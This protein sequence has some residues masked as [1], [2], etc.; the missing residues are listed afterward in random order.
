MAGLIGAD[1]LV[2]TLLEKRIGID[3]KYTVIVGAVGLIFT[4]IQNP[5][6]ISGA[7]RLGGA[8]PSQ[9]APPR[10]RRPSP[11][12]RQTECWS[13]GALEHHGM[14]VTFGGL[15][16]VDDVDLEVEQG[17]LVGLIGPN[18]AGKTTLIGAD[19]LRPSTG[20]LV[21]DGREIGA[22]SAH[23]RAALG[24]GRTWQSL[25]CSTS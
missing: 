22:L 8:V 18:G 20:R 21:F 11:G 15:R 16:A 10:R 24:L 1:A 5:E 2:F 19:R 14:V 9:P 3:P 7:L 13:D 25:S 6:G 12:R 4:A 17:S 23:R